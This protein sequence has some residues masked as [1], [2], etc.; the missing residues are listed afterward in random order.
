MLLRPAQPP[1]YFCPPAP[2]QA[3]DSSQNPA[4]Q[5][6]MSK[7][8]RKQLPSAPQASPWRLQRAD[9]QPLRSMSPRLVSHVTLA[10]AFHG[11]V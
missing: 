3:Q 7:A 2:R 5:M 10:S 4:H 11:W 1:A 9:R 8:R 6:E